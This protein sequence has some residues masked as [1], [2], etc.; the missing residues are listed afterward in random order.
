MQ[1]QA[2]K[3]AAVRSPRDLFGA[4][5]CSPP[6]PVGQFQQ[7][8]SHSVEQM[9]MELEST[10]TN[11]FIDWSV[12]RPD[13]FE[14][15]KELDA[16]RGPRKP[17]S[18]KSTPSTRRPGSANATEPDETDWALRE[19]P[20]YYHLQ[21]SRLERSRRSIG[22]STSR[23]LNVRE[24]QIPEEA[25]AHPSTL[26]KQ[27]LDYEDLVKASGLQSVTD[28]AFEIL[29]PELHMQVNA[30]STRPE[31][32]ADLVATADSSAQALL[33]PTPAP[34]PTLS[35][36]STAAASRAARIPEGAVITLSLHHPDR[37]HHRL[38]QIDL[39]AHQSLTDVRDAFFCASDFTNPNDRTLND[40]QGK[41]TSGSFF[42]IEN[43]FFVDGRAGFRA[44]DYAQPLI[45]WYAARGQV[46]SKRPM[47]LRLSDLTLRINAPYAFVHQGGC[48]HLVV[49]Q[50]IRLRHHVE[51]A[52]AVFPRTAFRSHTLRPKCAICDFRPVKFV[53]YNDRGAGSNPCRWCSECYYSV[54]Y[55]KANE[56]LY[57]DFQVFEFVPDS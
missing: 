38:Q 37:P 35:T 32:V 10:V 51:D 1:S 30:P 31:L 3:P 42:F 4:V 5:P 45:N 14:A 26:V 9:L 44:V 29:P 49:V 19:A 13:L 20:L 53:T 7:Q 54:H 33:P 16:A 48:E 28:A 22:V 12:D 21:Q 43:E 50:N 56:L 34:R 6:I 27:L 47:G 15:I 18:R 2:K 25:L 46:K 24:T 57:D 52:G 8:A 36:G 17:T 39:L 11:S 40:P 41:K 23:R 55:N